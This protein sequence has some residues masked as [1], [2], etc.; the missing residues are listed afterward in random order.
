MSSNTL[1]QL[2]EGSW[3]VPTCRDCLRPVQLVGA[4]SR[5]DDCE[6]MEVQA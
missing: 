3:I 1:I 6:C 2:P 4:E 5:S